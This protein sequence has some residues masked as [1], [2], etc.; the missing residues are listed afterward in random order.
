MRGLTRRGSAVL[1]LGLA[2]VAGGVL[3]GVRDLTR[4]GALLVLLPFIARFLVARR[5][6][7]AVSR[8]VVPPMVPPGT[9]ATVDLRLRNTGT[10]TS[11]Q[12]VAEERVTYALGDRPR[13][14]LARIGVDGER[15]ITYRARSHVRGRHHL[16]P[17]TVRVSDA[18]GLARREVVLPGES[19]V[20]VLPRTYP[21]SGLP[22]MQA[23]SGGEEESSHRV[24]LHGASD[25]GVRE[26]RDGDDLRRIHWPSTARTGSMMVR[27]DEQPGRRRALVLLDNQA[28]SHTGTGGA[29]SLEWAVSAAASV[30]THLV[31]RDHETYL[32]TADLTSEPMTPLPSVEE[33]LAAL[34][35]VTL[36]REDD[37][38]GLLEAAA[39]LSEHGGGTIIAVVGPL[40]E[41]AVRR[42]TR[43]GRGVALVVDPELFERGGTDVSAT[44][45]LLAA[46]GW[47]AVDVTAGARVTDLWSD[48]VA[49]GEA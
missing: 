40:D 49:G 5:F 20:L 30:A 27:Q 38:G 26:Y 19:S 28:S 12:L 37:A 45:V 3:L 29:G 9:P 21:L 39:E 18:F 8:D 48:L 15:Q 32:A 17:L 25:V 43:V 7:L 41:A 6:D 33:A 10:A 31:A 23:G 35:V 36:T 4:A 22:P 34:A 44:A 16:G 13:M 24:T 42:L 2:L 14:L 1:G 11:P 46:G 47:R